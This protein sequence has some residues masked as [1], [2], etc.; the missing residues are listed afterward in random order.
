MRMPERNEA[1]AMMATGFFATWSGFIMGAAVGV[2]IGLLLAPKPGRESREIV[3]ER[4]GQA[5]GAVQSRVEQARERL[6]RARGSE[7]SEGG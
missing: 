3:G 6:R 2:V 1:G 5:R 7:A 4:L